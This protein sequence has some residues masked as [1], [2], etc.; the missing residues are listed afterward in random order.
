M[1]LKWWTF[2]TGLSVI[3]FQA[4]PEKQGLVECGIKLSFGSVVFT[5]QTTFPN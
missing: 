1:V 4:L 5:Y 3:L 2:K